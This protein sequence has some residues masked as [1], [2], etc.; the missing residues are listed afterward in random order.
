MNTRGRKTERAYIHWR[1]ADLR[2]NQAE[3]WSAQQFP[4]ADY[5][6]F[7]D[8]GCLI[9]ALAVMLRHSGIE[10]EE[11]ESLFNPWILNRK[12]IDCG[13]F[14]PAADLEL[15][16]INRL[17]PLVYWGSIPYSR[18]ALLQIVEK[19]LPCLVTVPGEHAA[20]HFTTPLFTLPDDAIVFDP[21]SGMQRLSAYDR[22]CEIR[23]F[24]QKK[25]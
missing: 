16:Y 1:Q 17:Y 12:L 3:A 23:I 9:C 4:E 19:G 24:R 2:F 11:D 7:R 5:R 20:R 8:C 13:A 15:S 6:Y 22:I 14:T 25:E 10:K 18:E 21:F